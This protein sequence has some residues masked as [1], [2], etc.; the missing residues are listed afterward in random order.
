LL[1]RLP[2]CGHARLM[3][4]VL[5]AFATNE[6]FVVYDRSASGKK[7]ARRRAREL[8]VLPT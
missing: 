4:T 6:R 7:E 5:M 2:A 8:S 3:V 1:L